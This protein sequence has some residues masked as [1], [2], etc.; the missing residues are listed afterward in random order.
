MKKLKERISNLGLSIKKEL[1][2]A[3]AF[4]L[5][6]LALGI[7]AFYLLNSYI[8]LGVGLVFV[9]LFNL[10]YFSRYSKL[11]KEQNDLAK[12]DFVSLF[13][14]SKFISTTAILFIQH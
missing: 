8:Y 2:T 11:E 6:L 1:T 10:F 9:V 7:V 13:T 12:Q 4:S 14:F 3:L 5:V